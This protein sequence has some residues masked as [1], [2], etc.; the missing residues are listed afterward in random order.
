MISAE[1]EVLEGGINSGTWFRPEKRAIV[2]DHLHLD[3]RKLNRGGLLEPSWSGRLKW[4]AGNHELGSIDLAV[5]AG[6]RYPAAIRLGYRKYGE[7]IS[8]AIGISWT[9]CSFGG[10]RPWWH[11]PGNNCG[12]R[13][14]ILHLERYFLCR[15]CLDLAYQSTREPPIARYRQRAEKLRY[16]LGGLGRGSEPIPP[17]PK[18][19]HKTTYRRLSAELFEAE[20]A[21]NR[22]YCEWLWSL[23]HRLGPR[24]K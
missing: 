3:I 15:H 1:M 20:M 13:V 22:V 17:K 9:P 21:A 10:Y 14:A 8:Y 19:M 6:D 2:E 4:R 11:C 12:R 7:S 23:V 5:E 24:E 18:G 16:R